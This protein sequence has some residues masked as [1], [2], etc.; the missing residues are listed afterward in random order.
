MTFNTEKNK[1]FKIWN[2]SIEN[3]F[4]INILSDNDKIILSKVNQLNNVNTIYNN[5]INLSSDWLTPEISIRNQGEEDEILWKL[6]KE[7][8]I[9]INGINENLIP[10]IE[11]KIT[12][13]LG[14]SGI[15][16]PIPD[17]PDQPGVPFDEDATLYINDFYKITEEIEETRKNIIYK[18][19]IFL[20]NNDGLPEELQFKFYI[21]IFNPRY[22]QS[23]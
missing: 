10:Y 15:S 9:E 23:T 5:I 18:S 14:D 11:S 22:Y 19:S 8:T 2:D 6:F 17:A 4:Q 7:Y 3:Q 13:R 16:L 20:Q 12:Y 1:I 21:N